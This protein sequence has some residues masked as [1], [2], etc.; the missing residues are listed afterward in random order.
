MLTILLILSLAA[1]YILVRV[2]LDARREAADAERHARI[3]RRTASLAASELANALKREDE[4]LRRVLTAQRVMLA[5][6]HLPVLSSPA[7][8]RK[9]RPFQAICE[10]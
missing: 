7:G 8:P 5:C 3:A 4:L 10:N 2:A 6:R 9:L 1:N